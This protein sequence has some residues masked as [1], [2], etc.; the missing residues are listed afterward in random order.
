MIKFVEIFQD[1]FYVIVYGPSFWKKR[2]AF[3]NSDQERRCLGVFVMH[4][5][6]NFFSVSMKL[7]EKKKL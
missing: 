3:Q 2:K 4:S 7:C 1:V 6:N 5:N